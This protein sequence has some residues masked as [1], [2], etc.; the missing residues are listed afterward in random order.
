VQKIENKLATEAP[1]KVADLTTTAEK[2]K[3]KRGRKP[4]E[5]TQAVESKFPTEGKIN[6]YG[7]V[8]LDNDVL[9]A[10]GLSKGAEQRITVDLKDGNLII[11]KA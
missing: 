7:F 6:K 4:K 10:L 11:S 1:V 2:P 8:Y 3:A 5:P 9:A